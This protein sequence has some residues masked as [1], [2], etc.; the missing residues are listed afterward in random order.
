MRR[1][2]Q[3]MNTLRTPASLSRSYKNVNNI[4]SKEQ[5]EVGIITFNINTS[6]YK[7][8]NL[9]MTVN[10]S[11]LQVCHQNITGLVGKTHEISCSLLSDPPHMICL[12]ERLTLKKMCGK[13]KDIKQY[14]TE[15]KEF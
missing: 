15:S 10:A 8:M 6:K 9:Y 1:L 5:D 7:K 4:H 12:A 2:G 3:E 11:N 13:L 14:Q